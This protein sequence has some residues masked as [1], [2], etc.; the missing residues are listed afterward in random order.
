MKEIKEEVAGKT[1][2]LKNCKYFGFRMVWNVKKVNI[3]LSTIE[4]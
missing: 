3:A 4:A 1:N 2:V